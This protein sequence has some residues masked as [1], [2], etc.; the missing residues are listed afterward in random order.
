MAMKK[1]M[2]YLIGACILLM[3]YYF[4]LPATLFHDPYST[5]LESE[6]GELLSASIAADGQWRFPQQHHVPEKF[7]AAIV[8]FEDKR[9]WH[10]PGVDILAFA[11][12]L[13]QNISAGHVVSG[14]STL[15]MQVIRLSRKG[16][17]R[18]VFE[19]MW[20]LVLAT[21]LEFRSTKDQILHEYAAHAPFGGNV[22]GLEA[23]CWRYFGRTTRELSWAEAATLAVLPNAPALIHPGR[24]RTTLQVKRDKLLDK[25]WNTG[26]IDSLTCALAKAEP[27]PEEPRQLPR[28]ARHLL[29]TLQSSG[30][31]QQRIQSTLQRSLQQRIE[32]LLYEHHVQLQANQIRHAAVVVAEVQTGNVLA[33]AGNVTGTTTQRGD[34][35]DLI[36]APRSTGSILKPFLFAAALDEGKIL[37]ASLLPDVPVYLNG[38]T[39]KNFSRRYDGVVPANEALIRSLNVPAVYLLR[40]YRYEKFHALLKRLGMTTLSRPP[41]HYGLSL[42][43]GGAEGTL[44]DIAGMYASLGR[45]LNNYAEHPG[46]NKYFPNDIHPLVVQAN[47]QDTKSALEASARIH[48][49]AIYQTFEI[50]TELYRPGE[51][52]G[53]KLFTSARKIAWKTGTSFGFRDGWAVGITPR[54]VVGVWVGN[55]NGEGRPG[56]TGT[57]A[58]APIM[59]N[60]FAQ[61][62]VESNWFPL[63]KAEFSTIPVCAVSGARVATPCLQKDSVQVVT[64][65]LQSPACSYHKTIHLTADGK[66]RAHAGCVPLQHLQEQSWFVLP[67]VQEYYFKARNISYKPLPPFRQDCAALAT[68]HG[69]MD[70]IYPKANARIFIPR[71]LSGKTGQVIV[72]VAH[73]TPRAVVYWHLDETFVGATQ[74]KHRLELQP[75]VGTHRLTV[76]DDLGNF[77][78]TSFEVMSGM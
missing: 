47:H 58:A 2:Y 46:K 13:R 74:N 78:E 32:Q 23:A 44:W 38:F 72:E 3:G 51:E 15:T 77:L 31:D 17:P 5:V 6:N 52:S 22:V 36:R 75:A 10:H 33:Y 34:E 27:I 9:F 73:T 66:Y 40:D 29:V 41:E 65:G 43:L 67:P 28:L 11:R 35:V 62:P 39:P 25:L 14:G 7:A 53:W 8:A 45:T 70:F 30:Q 55:A 64:A 21:R 61:L 18:T 37:P 20:E 49:S 24:N 1:R 57:D 76:V 19:K 54:Y 4:S 12:A 26:L 59:F 60:V 56:L 68:Q 69:P 63:P 50:L 42:I 71:E 16:Q 48:A